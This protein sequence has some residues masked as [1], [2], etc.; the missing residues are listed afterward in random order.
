M[1]G[2]SGKAPLPRGRKRNTMIVSQSLLER[3][4]D[5]QIP[6]FIILTFNGQPLSCGI[7]ES[8]HQRFE[9]NPQSYNSS[10]SSD[11]LIPFTSGETEAQRARGPWTKTRHLVNAGVCLHTQISLTPKHIQFCMPSYLPSE[12]NVFELSCYNWRAGALKQVVDGS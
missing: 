2:A 7:L 4:V 8:S 12:E 1:I 5:A 9:H 3:A 11:S 6:C 10:A